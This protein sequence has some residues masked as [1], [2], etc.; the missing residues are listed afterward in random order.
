MAIEAKHL[1]SMT[2]INKHFSGERSELFSLPTT[3]GRQEAKRLASTLTINKQFCQVKEAS[4]FASYNQW[5]TRSETSR[6]HTHNKYTVFRWKK[7]VVSLP[8]TNGRQEAKRLA[9]TLT[10]NKQFC[11][12]KEASCFASYNQWATRS[13]T[14]RIHTHNKYTVL[15]G[16]RSELFRFLQPMGDKKRNVSHSHTHN[17]YTVFRWKKRVVSL[18]TTNG[19]QEAKRL[20]STLTINKQFCQVK[21]ASCFASYNQWATRSETSRIH[22]HNK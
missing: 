12:V 18:P 2:T 21:E 11:Q 1:A 3:N 17:K 4:C 7:R 6:I 22:T 9:S 10:I 19:R 5:A 15:S 13:E 20:A 8:T 16:E 14:S